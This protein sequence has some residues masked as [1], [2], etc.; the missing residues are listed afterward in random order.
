M[1]A[2]NEAKPVYRFMQK[3]H[4]VNKPYYTRWAEHCAMEYVS[5]IHMQD[6]M[7]EELISCP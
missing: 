4:Y 7:K 1:E 3:L 5:T 6:V 2:G